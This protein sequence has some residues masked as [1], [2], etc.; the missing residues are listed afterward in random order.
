MPRIQR[1][2]SRPWPLRKLDQAD[3]PFRSL[4]FEGLYAYL[5]LSVCV[6]GLFLS[7]AGPL[8]VV[9]TGGL[10]PFNF[11][12]RLG[13][14]NPHVQIYGN[15]L[16]ATDTRKT[17]TLDWLAPWPNYTKNKLSWYRQGLHE[18]KVNRAV[19]ESLVT[20]DVPDIL[21]A[22]AIANQGNSYQRPFGWRSFEHWQRQLGNHYDWPWPQWDWGQRKWNA[23]FEQYSI[24]IAQIMPGEIEQLGYDAA[25]IDLFDSAT[26][27]DLMRAKLVATGRAAKSLDVNKTDSFIL[28]AIGN[29]AGLCAIDTYQ[30]YGGDMQTF[31]ANDALSRRQLA[32][33]ISYVDYLHVQEG[34]PL[35]EGVNF[36]HI[37]WL[38]RRAKAGP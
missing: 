28:V 17:L 32:K 15:V 19:I 33:M 18:V 8:S 3:D 31:L 36:D 23:Y 9:G 5:L 22:A 34:W 2:Q 38:I 4:P 21:V 6:L 13:I 35:P 10:Y 37:W 1:P 14:T 25:K 27:I 16:G 12:T 29:N 7:G 11:L 26:S 24:G 30:K 20:Y